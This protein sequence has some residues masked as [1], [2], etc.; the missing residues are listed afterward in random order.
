MNLCV[1]APADGW[2]FLDLKRAAGSDCRIDHFEFG[3][4]TDVLLPTGFGSMTTDS[5]QQHLLQNFDCVLARAM[6][7]GTLQQV[8]FRMDV[9]LEL[10][11]RGLR[12]VNPPRTIEMSVDKYLSLCQLNRH[13]IPVPP[14]A[15]SQNFSSAMEQFEML[16]G[17]VVLKPLF[18]SMGRGLHKIDTRKIAERK[19]ADA[20]ATEG[21]VYQQAFIEHD[22]FDL[23]LLVIG[24]EVL[25][26]KRVNANSWITNLAQGA[27]GQPHSATENEIELAL[28]SARAVGAE[29]VGVDLVYDRNSG[30]PFVLEVNSAPSWQGL[31][32]VVKVDVAQK[33][34]DYL[35]RS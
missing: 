1:L 23:R 19:F 27:I 13:A 31:A 35:S 20:L 8:I 7:F 18:G 12:I 16:G 33:I 4:L 25:A 14:T 10:Q 2:H 6:P 11:Q 9:L 30:Q 17:S 29:I 32:G 15:V 22:G 28:R 5:I 3:N 24:D 21:T 26:M 34:L